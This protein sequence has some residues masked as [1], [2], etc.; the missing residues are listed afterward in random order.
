MTASKPLLLVDLQHQTTVSEQLPVVVVAGCVEYDR[1][2]VSSG[3]KT[4]FYT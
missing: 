1:V 3:H 2:G 4:A